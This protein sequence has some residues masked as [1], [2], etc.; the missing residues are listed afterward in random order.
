MRISGL[1]R[2]RRRSRRKSPKVSNLE[3]RSM[4]C[5]SYGDELGEG[6]LI[7]LAWDGVYDTAGAAGVQC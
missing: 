5:G 6:K 4:I 7:Y 3:N 1:K 2:P